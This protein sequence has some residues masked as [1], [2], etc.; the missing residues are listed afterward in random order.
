MYNIDEMHASPLY[1]DWPCD[2]YVEA[3]LNSY[4]PDCKTARAPRRYDGLEDSK[5]TPHRLWW[6]EMIRKFCVPKA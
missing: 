6:I 2:A 4:V 3:R 1:N 5:P